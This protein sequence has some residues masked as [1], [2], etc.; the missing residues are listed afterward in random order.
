MKREPWVV[1]ALVAVIAS[2]ATLIVVDF[3]GRR[4]TY[5]QGSAQTG[6]LAVIAGSIIRDRMMPIVIVDAQAQVIMTYDYICSGGTR[7]ELELTTARSFKYDRRLLDYN[8][9]NYKSLRGS[10][11]SYRHHRHSAGNSV[12]EIRV[13]TQ[14]QPSL[15]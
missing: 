9:R 6:Y 11:M 3:A 14:K 4:E 12:N 7:R 1:T 15:E 10:R 8:I 5:A 13:A 2:L